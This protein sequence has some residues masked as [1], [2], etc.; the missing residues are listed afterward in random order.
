MG[1]FEF[2]RRKPVGRAMPS[3]RRTVD[4]VQQGLGRRRRLDVQRA[5]HSRRVAAETAV[6]PEDVG[7]RI[8]HGRARKRDRL[9]DKVAETLAAGTVRD[10]RVEGLAGV[11]RGDQ[12]PP[13]LRE[14]PERVADCSRLVPELRLLG[15][16]MVGQPDGPAGREDGGAPCRRLFEAGRFVPIDEHRSRRAASR[17]AHAYIAVGAGAGQPRLVA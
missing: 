16:A 5:E 15:V 3:L 7:Q 12:C 1:V 17:Q 14:C 2:G 8:R 6:A 11:P 4:R 10:H 9:G 13:Q